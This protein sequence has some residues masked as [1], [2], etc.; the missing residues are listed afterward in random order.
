MT[1][2]WN[3]DCSLLKAPSIVAVIWRCRGTFTDCF[4][5]VSPNHTTYSVKFLGYQ[6]LPFRT[7]LSTKADLR[8]DV[9][10]LGG[11]IKN[12]PKKAL[13]SSGLTMA[14]LKINHFQA[15]GCVE[16]DPFK[17]PCQCFLDVPCQRQLLHHWTWKAYLNAKQGGSHS[18]TPQKKTKT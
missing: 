10:C 2:L 18:S 13:E 7:C 5:K 17:Q 4:S 6:T 3:F 15:K 11:I 16:S 8:N 1:T 14:W 9:M 12:P